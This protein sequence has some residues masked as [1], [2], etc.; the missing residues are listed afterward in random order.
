[1]KRTL[2]FFLTAFLF[3]N[4]P[5]FSQV[6]VSPN[7][8]GNNGASHGVGI[9]DQVVTS[10]YLGGNAFLQGY[11]FSVN[12]DST[13][14]KGIYAFNG[15][16]SDAS[17]NYYTTPFTASDGKMYGSSYVGGTANLGTVYS[18]D[19]ASA[20]CNADAIIFNNTG[21]ASGAGNY[22]NVNELSDG[23][24]YAVNT[25]GGAF[26]LGGI[27]RMS[28]TGASPTLI[29]SFSNTNFV[30]Y[31]AAAVVTSGIITSGA[32]QNNFDG[33][34][35]YAFVIEG[36]DGMIYGTTVN[37]GKFNT[38]VVY[39]CDKDGSNYEVIL[40]G[41]GAGTPAIPVGDPL[42]GVDGPLTSFPNSNWFVYP[43]GNVA[44]AENGTMYVTDYQ[45]A[46][47]S[48]AAAYGNIIKFQPDGSNV[49]IVAGHT[50]TDRN[51][52]RGLLYINEVGL[53]G[54]SFPGGPSALGQ[55]YKL[56]TGAV[57]VPAP[58]IPL[59]N[60]TGYTGV[61]ATSDGALPFANCVYDGTFLYGSTQIGGTKQGGTVYKIKPDG[62]DYLVLHNFDNTAP[63][64]CGTNGSIANVF[65]YYPSNERVTL[66]TLGGACGVIC[67]SPLPVNLVEFN[68]VRDN[69][70]AVIYWKTADEIN[71]KEFKVLHSS[72]IIH[73]D[74][75]ATVPATG[76][77]I[78]QLNEYSYTHRAPGV[79]KH[80]YKLAQVDWDGKE[81]YSKIGTILFAGSGLSVTAYPNPVT[82]NQNVSLQVSG[83]NSNVEFLVE[84]TDVQGKQI[85]TFPTDKNGRTSFSL[86]DK[87]KGMYIIKVTSPDL[88]G[89]TQL[90]MINN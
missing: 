15:F 56:D 31:S 67:N 1:M 23:N 76:V 83:S 79:G 12:K 81:M 52:Y 13:D 18:F 29:H 80:Y 46:V 37:G 25:I 49:R 61:P 63:A 27:Y 2:T 28:K 7:Q 82:D 85:M 19:P 77:N 58:I 9:G 74:A 62:T 16:P 4:Q 86:K 22:A 47:P 3:T 68:V 54:A 24:I 48:S 89:T 51:N 60:F 17:Y 66:A 26:A 43:W 50:A 70:N 40:S 14:A 78:G 32:G 38:G 5:G 57:Q 35:P 11:L 6:W 90:K 34:V 73:W 44:Q 59:H 75:L 55:L 36:I 20:L 41:G 8:P 72:D 88:K 33:A 45:G 87:A 30:N 84:V 53:I 69:K 39:R 71:N 65:A 42:L 64:N 10:T 21:G